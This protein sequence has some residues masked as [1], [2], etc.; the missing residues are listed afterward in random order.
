MGFLPHN[1]SQWTQYAGQHDN[2]TDI[3]IIIITQKSTFHFI[4]AKIIKS[5]EQACLKNVN[6]M[7]ANSSNWLLEKYKQLL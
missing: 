7:Q 4:S 5:C 1:Y 3:N 2:F 6:N